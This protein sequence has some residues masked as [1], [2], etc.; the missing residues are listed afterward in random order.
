MV[1]YFVLISSVS[2]PPEQVIISFA[3]DS[4][5]FLLP[6]VFYL[7]ITRDF[8]LCQTEDLYNLSS[9][10]SLDNKQFNIQYIYC[11]YMQ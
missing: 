11:V 8:K 4:K 3:I 5:L 1:T 7:L 6:I 9:M 10:S 2:L